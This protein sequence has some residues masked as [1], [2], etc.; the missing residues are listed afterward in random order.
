MQVFITGTDTNIGKTLVC[1]WLCMHLRYPYFKPIQ[2][3]SSEGRDS[4]TVETLSHVKCYPESYCY[5][6]PIAPNAAA[7]LHNEEIDID[8]IILPKT[9]DLIVEGAGGIMTPINEKL[10]IIDL[11]QRFMIPVIVTISPKL[12]TINHTL[13]TIKILEEYNIKI[14]GIIV[15]GIISQDTVQIIQ[16][17]THVKILAQIPFLHKVDTQALLNFTMPL[18]LQKIF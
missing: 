12:G 14:L 3:G 2:T 11:I 13:M 18:K 7:R 4:V 17:H 1:S 9:P 15:S 10:F 6:E 8:R 5:L 16:D